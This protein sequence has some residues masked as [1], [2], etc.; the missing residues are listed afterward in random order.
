VVPRNGLAA[1]AAGATKG[2]ASVNNKSDQVERRAL[3]GSTATTTYH[4]QAKIAQELELGGRFANEEIN[5]G[6][7]AATMYP[8]LPSSSPW[9]ADGVGGEPPLGISVDDMQPTGG[10][11]EIERSLAKL[12]E[13][14]PTL[15]T[16]SLATVVRDA[17]ANPIV[18]RRN[19]R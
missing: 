9:A 17:S 10:A 7:E 3:A 16:S 6:A 14:A 15:A 13:V 12:A 8:R 4:R 11:F 5:S 2:T 19:L 1:V 18:K